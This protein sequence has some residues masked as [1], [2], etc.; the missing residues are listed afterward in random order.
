M[1]ISLEKHRTNVETDEST[2][3]QETRRKS[4]KDKKKHNDK[5]EAKKT[6]AFFFCRD[7]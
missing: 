2:E 6:E 1:T 5:Y 3:Q 7:F 4:T